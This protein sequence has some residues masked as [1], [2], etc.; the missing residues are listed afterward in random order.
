LPQSVDVTFTRLID[1]LD[2]TFSHWAAQ[3]GLP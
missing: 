3:A 1:S 2:A